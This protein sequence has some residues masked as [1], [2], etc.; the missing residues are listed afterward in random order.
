[1]SEVRKRKEANP[2]LTEK[3]SPGVNVM[4]KDEWTVGE[5]YRLKAAQILG[6]FIF[7]QQTTLECQETLKEQTVQQIKVSS[8]KCKRKCKF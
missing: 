1:M 2:L 7:K 8:T 6:H 4:S 5:W 3:W